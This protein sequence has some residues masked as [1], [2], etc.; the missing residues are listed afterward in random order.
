MIYSSFTS[1]N[2]SRPSRKNLAQCM[3]PH[4][5][6]SRPLHQASIPPS[7]SRGSYHLYSAAAADRPQPAGDAPN[8]RI[9]KLFCASCDLL[10]LNLRIGHL[11]LQYMPISHIVQP[12]DKRAL[13]P[14]SACCG[15]RLNLRNGISGRRFLS[16]RAP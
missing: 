15:L 3:Q 13:L 4:Y 12:L 8:P 7:R 9:L 1:L 6:P 11:N 14:L 16:I 10:G 5:L 2:G